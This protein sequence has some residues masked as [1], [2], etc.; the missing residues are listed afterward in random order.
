MRLINI[1]FLEVTVRGRFCYPGNL[2]LWKVLTISFQTLQFWPYPSKHWNSHL[3]LPNIGILTLSFQTLEFPPYPSNTGIPILSFQTLEFPPH[4]SK[5]GNSNLILQNIGI[6]TLFFQTLEFSPYPSKHWNS[7][8]IHP[9]IGIPNLT[10]QTF[11]KSKHNPLAFL[12]ICHKTTSLHML[13][14]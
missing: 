5:H 14:S 9:N 12:T 10:F 13:P 4:P 1:T 8:L 6:L 7:N 11:L 3:I 2:T